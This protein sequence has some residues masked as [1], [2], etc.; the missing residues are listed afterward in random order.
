MKVNV[1]ISM[2]KEF[3]KK[4]HE[5]CE[6]QGYNNFS[7]WIRSLIVKHAFGKEGNKGSDRT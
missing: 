6:E 1:N 5:V 7:A 2:D 3:S 4:A